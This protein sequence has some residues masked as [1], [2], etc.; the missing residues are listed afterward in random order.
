MDLVVGDLSFISLRTVLDPLL[1][2]VRPGGDLVL[3]VKPQFE[4]GRVEASRGKGVIRDPEVR[5]AALADVRTALSDRGA[6]IMGEMTSPLKG[7]A[8]NVEFLV[9]ARA[10]ERDGDEPGRTRPPPSA[11]GGGDR[12]PRG[13]RAGWPSGATRSSCPRP[14]PRWRA[15][16]THG[17]PEDWFGQELDLVVSLGGDGT[18]LRTVSLVA[19]FDVPILGVNFG[20]L[21]LPDRGR[22]RRARRGAGPLLRRRAPHRGAHAHRGPLGRRR[23]RR[24][25]PLGRPQRGGAGADGGGPHGPA[26]RRPRRRVLHHVRSRCPDRGHAHGVDRLLALGPGARSSP[27]TTGRSC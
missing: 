22:A 7:G 23:R 19:E 12:H 1:T 20:Q 10:Q 3:L 21:G 17:V 13:G 4:V 5:A 8:G 15:W 25:A 6:V 18:M 27:P 26:R 24:G 14:T 16:R 9:H 2:A 11:G